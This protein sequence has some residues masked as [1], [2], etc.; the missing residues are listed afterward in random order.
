[1]L[2]LNAQTVCVSPLVSDLSLESTLQDLSLHN[3]QIEIHRSSH[4][5]GRIFEENPLLPG[6]I[7]L[8][9]GQFLG[10]ISRRQFLRHM[11]RP[12]G[13]EIFSRRSLRT[14]YEFARTDAL[15]FPGNTSIPFAAQKA[16]QRP[17]GALQE[18]IVVQLDSQ[19]Y[20]LLDAHQLFIVQAK[21]HELTVQ[22]LQEKT[23]AQMI[24]NEKM[25]GLGQMVAGVAHEILNPVNFIWGNLNYLADYSQ[26]LMQILAA[27]EC[28]FPQ[29]SEQIDELKAEID[30]EFLCK[31][32]P[33]VL[34]SMKLGTERLKKIISALRNFSHMDEVNRRP[35][36]LHECLDNTLLIVSN[37]T[38][39]GIEILRN[40]GELP[41]V[42]CYSGQLNQVFMNL[43]SN[44]IDALIEL[45]RTTKPQDW[46]PQIVLST[47][48]VTDQ[49]ENKLLKQE[50]DV[51]AVLIR[52]LDNGPGI[53]PEIQ[54]QV[55]ETFFTT[56]PVGKGTGLG[57]AISRQ[58]VVEKHQGKLDFR[59]QL[60]I[61]TEFEVWLPLS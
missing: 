21:I 38:K 22:L 59:S 24:Q 42:N 10:M 18:P 14:L 54:K 58:I 60:G 53:A 33:Q 25:A 51:Q 55:F 19:D 56:K 61:G 5:V 48:V 35:I 1:M 44:A 20:R 41:L 11:S 47:E 50:E 40:Y 28:E 12:Y 8:D 36:D 29:A 2:M 3:C 49:G 46:Q 16:V 23:Q 7:L 31:D 30:F 52:I 45:D 17:S 26:D 57:L 39:Y 6:V 34:A 43:I 32:F 9:Q 37:R 27:Y 4:E 13:L 15:I